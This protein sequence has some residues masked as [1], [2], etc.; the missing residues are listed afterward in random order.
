M[1]PEQIAQRLLN[2]IRST[3]ARNNI[4]TQLEVYQN[5]VD[6]LEREMG[7]L[8]DEGFVEDEMFGQNDNDDE[9]DTQ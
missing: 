7:D 1:N 2:T 9:E 8:E 3:V 5:L 4:A 6:K